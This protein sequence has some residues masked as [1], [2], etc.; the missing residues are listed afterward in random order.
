MIMGILGEIKGETKGEKKWLS[1]TKMVIVPPKWSNLSKN[2]NR[3]SK[4]YG[5]SK[6]DEYGGSRER[7]K[8]GPSRWNQGVAGQGSRVLILLAVVLVVA[9]GFCEEFQF[10]GVFAMSILLK[11]ITSLSFNKCR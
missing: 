4:K 6:N 10:K 1:L 3:A 8:Y 11:Q 2:G 9:L 5:T 7:K